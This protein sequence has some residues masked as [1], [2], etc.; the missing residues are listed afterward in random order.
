MPPKKKKI[1]LKKKKKPFRKNNCSDTSDSDRVRTYDTNVYKPLQEGA[2]GILLNKVNYELNRIRRNSNRPYCH[3][4][5]Q[6]VYGQYSHVRFSKN[7]HNTSRG[8]HHIVA[9]EKYNVKKL[10]KGND[11]SHLCG[12]KMCALKE[13]LVIEPH[14]VNISRSRTC[15]RAGYSGPCVHSPKCI[16]L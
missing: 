4:I 1:P 12:N 10:I 5:I 14:G 2:F 9:F 8:V 13:H 3:E 15:H 7:D 11:V 6:N 16:V